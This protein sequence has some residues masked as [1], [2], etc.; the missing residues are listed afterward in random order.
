LLYESIRN[1]IT[2]VFGAKDSAVLTHR[3]YLEATPAAL[4]ITRHYEIQVAAN[5]GEPA[6]TF[7][8]P[9]KMEGAFIG[10]VQLAASVKGA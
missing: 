5:G 9:I 6:I 10:I 4:A 1:P 7:T 3:L 2:Q 8:N